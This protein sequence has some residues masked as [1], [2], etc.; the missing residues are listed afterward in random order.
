MTSE[1][2]ADQQWFR[3]ADGKSLLSGSPLTSF[4]VSEAGAQILNAIENNDQLPPHHASLTSRLLATGAIHPQTN[5]S[6]PSSDITV[7]IPAFITDSHSQQQLASLLEHLSDMAVIVVD[8]CSPT[9]LR[10][11]NITVIRRDTN[12]GPG[13]ARNTGIQHVTTKFA[14]FVDADVVTSSD[15]L[16]QLASVLRDESV[17]LAAPRI[18]TENEKT[19]LSEYESLRSPLDLGN[20]PAVV[21]PLSR[22]SYVPSAVLVGRTIQLREQFS[23]NETMRLGEDV[24]LIWRIVESGQIV[25]YVPS[26][27]CHHRARTSWSALLK[28]RFGYGSSAATLNSRHPR[29]ASPLRANV[30][31]LLPAV[32]L[33]SGYLYFAVMLALPMYF[34][35]AT[36]LQSTGMSLR[37]R[38]KV[39][40]IGFKATLRLLASAVRRAWWPIVTLSSLVFQPMMFVL[41]FSVLAAPAYG[42][43]KR[44]P[45]YPGEYFVM[46]ILDD[47]AYGL[48]V[49]AGAIRTRSFGCLLPII[50]LRRSSPQK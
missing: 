41:L 29:A 13:A 6:V 18:A 5:L 36:T 22:V 7:V 30:V 14:A 12:G 21:R 37:Q 27:I 48:G 1:F 34:Y 19:F 25:R 11:S 20:E 28:Q 17:A 26:V 2:I 49:W 35:F 42:I 23:F 47:C 50:T 33:L 16:R 46:R 15:S 8:D 45:R 44:K 24:D 3:S 4:T 39:T 40:T 10:I 9:P 32:A 31:L 38:F 43:V